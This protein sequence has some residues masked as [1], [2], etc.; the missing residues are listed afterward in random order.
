MTTDDISQALEGIAEAKRGNTFLGFQLLKSS[1]DMP[2]LPEAK[3]WYGYCLANEKN[4]F[5]HGI[6]LCNEARQAKPRSSDIYLALGRLYLLAKRRSSAVKTLQQGLTLDNNQEI[7]RL[8]NGIG[9]RKPPVF[10]FLDRNN[11][12]NVTSGRR[13]SKIGLR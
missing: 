11:K 8:L 5:R 7:S 4:D 3:A 12:F 6:A 9:I 10:R 1:I 2:H 13:L